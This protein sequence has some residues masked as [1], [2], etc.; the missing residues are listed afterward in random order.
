M[1]RS[2]TVTMAQADWEEAYYALE[3]KVKG[4]EAGNYG[5]EDNPGDDEKWIRH[6]K[7]IMRKIEKQVEV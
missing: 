1:A 5:P 4:I 6:L 2:I 3:T 7:A